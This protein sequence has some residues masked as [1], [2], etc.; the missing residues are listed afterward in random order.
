MQLQSEVED[1]SRDARN[2]EEKAKKA[3]TDV[4]HFEIFLPLRS[5][6]DC[7]I[8]AP[9]PFP[10]L[11]QFPLARLGP[12]AGHTWCALLPIPIEVSVAP[13]AYLKAG[14]EK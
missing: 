1:A 2:A 4:G 11:T 12:R 9:C 3:I 8:K 7:V 6:L 14:Y 10:T 5:C 13:R